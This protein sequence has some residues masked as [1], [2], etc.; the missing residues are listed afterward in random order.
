MT[1][2][3]EER[4]NALRRE[5]AAKVI[6]A[7]QLMKVRRQLAQDLLDHERARYQGAHNRESSGAA[8]ELA[9]KICAAQ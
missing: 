9:P 3:E 1:K 6:A 7:I 5:K 8:W 4:Q 2:Q